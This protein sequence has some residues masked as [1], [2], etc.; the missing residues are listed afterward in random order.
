MENRSTQNNS[1]NIGN[2]DIIQNLNKIFNYADDKIQFKSG[3]ENE[4][5][6]LVLEIEEFINQNYIKKKNNYKNG[7]KIN[8]F[9]K[10]QLMKEIYPKN[11]NIK[12]NY[13][14]ELNDGETLF[15]EKNKEYKTITISK[16]TYQKG[17]IFELDKNKKI[18]LIILIQTKDGKDNISLYCLDVNN[19]PRKNIIIEHHLNVPPIKDYS[20]YILDQIEQK[21]I[22][23]LFGCEKE[24]HSFE[25]GFNKSN[26]KL[27]D[28]IK[29]ENTYDVDELTSI[30]L[31]RKIEM[32]DEFLEK[33]NLYNT[34]FFLVSSKSNLKLFKYDEKGNII[35]I[36]DIEIEK[37]NNDIYNGKIDIKKIRQLDNGILIIHL[38]NK[39]FN[40]CLIMKEKKEKEKKDV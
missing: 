11:E 9:I 39:K 40:S 31:I 14:L 28:Y 25:I 7:N 12:S 24:I 38:G 8:N 29:R 18:V 22:I 36:C 26:N 35:Y 19:H 30:C 21:E 10:V 23:M 4:K 15:I 32:V 2:K 1:N 5:R 20:Y 17:E 37:E 3:S 27:D 13:Y 33:N 6:D 16:E 34:G